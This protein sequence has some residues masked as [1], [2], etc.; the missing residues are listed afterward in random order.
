MCSTRFGEQCLTCESSKCHECELSTSDVLHNS[1]CVDCE[2]DMSN[3]LC[4]QTDGESTLTCLQCVEGYYVLDGTCYLWQSHCLTCEDQTGKC[5]QCQDRYDCIDG[6]NTCQ[7]CQSNNLYECDAQ[8]GSLTSC[9]DNNYLR[10][11]NWLSCEETHSQYLI[12]Q[13]SDDS[14]NCSQCPVGYVHDVED[15]CDACLTIPGCVE[16]RNS[17]GTSE[18]TIRKWLKSQDD[19][20]LKMVNVRRFN[21]WKKALKMIAQNVKEILFYLKTNAK[22]VGKLWKDVWRWMKTMNVS[23]VIHRTILQVEMNVEN[24]WL[25]EVQHVEKM[26]EV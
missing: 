6:T 14:I 19:Y 10:D 12:C 18:T 8:T 5:T 22:R 4:C 16:W 3:C 13:T 2:N 23:N 9:N 21:D 20:R 17:V 24:D 11:D 25:K 15:E 7:S 1:R 26:E